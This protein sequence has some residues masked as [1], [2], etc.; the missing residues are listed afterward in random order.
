MNRRKRIRCDAKRIRY[1]ALGT[2]RKRIRSVALSG[3]AMMPQN[4]VRLPL[5]YCR[6]AS[7]TLLTK[8][9]NAVDVCRQFIS[10][11]FTTNNLQVSEIRLLSSPIRYRVG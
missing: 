6:P 5:F 3:I 4:V 8:V 9:G 7:T 2:V 10:A 1:D 11:L